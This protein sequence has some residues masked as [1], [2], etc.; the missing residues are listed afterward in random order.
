MKILLIGSTGLLGS[1]F[2]K[3][4]EK[5]RHDLLAP[6]RA[7][8]NIT[9]A[10]NLKVFFGKIQPELIINCAAY[11]AVDLAETEREKAYLLNAKAIENL[12]DTGVPLINFSTDYVFDYDL[13]V[14]DIPENYTRKAVNYYG[15][16]KLEGERILD[17]S[18]VPFW[19][20]RTSWLF[21]PAG[22]NFVA[23]ILQISEN[24]DELKIVADQ[25]GRPTYAPDLAAFVVEHFVNSL[26]Q[27][28]S[29]SPFKKGDLKVP[30]GHY[31]LQN[32]GQL[33]SWAEFA[34]YFLKLKKWP[35][36]LVQIPTSEYPTAARRPGNSGMA[37]TKLEVQMRDWR[38]AV[39]E[40]L[41]QY[42][43]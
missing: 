25:Y 19:N 21:G 43:F 23:T 2:K 39:E 12:C 34:E 27:N 7:T 15:A 5:S 3:I 22:K 13:K 32:S 24:R 9:E 11:T 10:D 8:L 33:V 38:E 6:C 30:I 17:Q 1:E 26:A 20:I 16:T 28:P 31:H 37:N 18:E 14:G 36:T 35:G 42:R 29:K 40:Y 4:L 41:L